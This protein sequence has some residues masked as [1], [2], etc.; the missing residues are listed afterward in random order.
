MLEIK[1][2][3]KSIKFYYFILLSTLFL[4]PIKGL[5]AFMEE[6]ISFLGMVVDQ[7]YDPVLIW[8]KF[9]VKF[10]SS[11]LFFIGGYYLIQTLN[12]KNLSE[13]FTVEKITLFNKSGKIF[14]YSAFI[15]SITFI[16]DILNGTFTN[17]KSNNDF[18]FSLYFLII[19][20]S[21]LIVFS[22]ILQAAK[23]IKEEND[24]TI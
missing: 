8:I 6:D 5:F 22:K 3:V 20:G 21:F 4:I 13:I 19:I 10:L 18:I 24:L 15:G 17:L 14:Q 12:F 9:W 11:I 23:D 7:N 2:L 1:S 16:V